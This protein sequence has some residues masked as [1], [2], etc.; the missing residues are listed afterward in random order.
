MASM[1]TGQWA[2]RQVASPGVPHP[3]LSSYDV[4]AELKSERKSLTGSKAGIEV[5]KVAK[6]S[7]HDAELNLA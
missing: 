5:Y 1:R 6:V 4:P 3:S 2:L 7:L